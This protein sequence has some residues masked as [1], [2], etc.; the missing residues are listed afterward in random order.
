VIEED[1]D[2]YIGR[3]LIKASMRDLCRA[4]GQEEVPQ[5]EPYKVIVFCDFFKAGLQFP[6]DDFV[7]KILR[8]FNL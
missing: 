5:P 2:G 4:P 6:Y 1:L 3:G 8:R 7:G